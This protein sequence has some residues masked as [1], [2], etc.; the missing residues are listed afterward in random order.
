[1]ASEAPRSLSENLKNLKIDSIVV[2]DDARNIS[3]EEVKK[4]REELSIYDGEV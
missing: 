4:I 2:V 3:P 1:M